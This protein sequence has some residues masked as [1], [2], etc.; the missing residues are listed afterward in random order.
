MIRPVGGSLSDYWVPYD[1]DVNAALQA[2]REDV[3]RRGEFFSYEDEPD[4][5]TIEELLESQDEAGTH[6]ILDMDRISETPENA[7]GVVSPVGSDDSPVGSDELLAL[8]GTETP[9]R[10]EVEAREDD[11]FE[12]LAAF[13]RM[14]R[15]GWWCG[16]YLVAY[17]DGNPDELF[18]YVASGD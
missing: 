13:E 12:S 3:F 18:F 14:R 10:A 11:L 9:T 6:S 7:H 2:L 1:P 5:E 16:V 8:F 15:T 17:R 4:F